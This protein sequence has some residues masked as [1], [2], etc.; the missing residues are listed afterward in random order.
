MFSYEKHISEIILYLL[1]STLNSWTEYFTSDPVSHCMVGL[2][3]PMDVKGLLKTIEH[4]QMYILVLL[5]QLS[6]TEEQ[7]ILNLKQ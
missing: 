3:E 7:T 2:W 1:L 6:I 5:F 4:I